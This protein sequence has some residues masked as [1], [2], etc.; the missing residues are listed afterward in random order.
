MKKTSYFY[1][2]IFC[3]AAIISLIYYICFINFNNGNNSQMPDNVNYPQLDTVEG[4]KKDASESI[5][6]AN[7]DSAQKSEYVT[8]SS[9]AGYMMKADGDNVNLFEIYENGYSE[10]I[11]TLDIN[12][13]L[14]RKIDREELGAGIKRDTYA[15]ICSLIEDFSS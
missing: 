9:V 4:A 11:K 7:D 13:K 15:E 6:A 2:I 3:I 14:L 5:E 1:I 8:D 12:P 10:K